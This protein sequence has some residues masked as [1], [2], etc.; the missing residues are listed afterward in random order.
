MPAACQLPAIAA[1]WR[2]SDAVS[3]STPDSAECMDDGGP[4]LASTWAGA[5]TGVGVEAGQNVH[6]LLGMH[7]V[8]RRRRACEFSRANLARAL[9]AR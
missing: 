9:S 6:V 5:G 7:I 8:E 3:G 1:S 2:A 4:D